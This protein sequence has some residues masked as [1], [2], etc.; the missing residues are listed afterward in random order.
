MIYTAPAKDPEP[1]P[2]CPRRRFFRRCN[3]VVRKYEFFDRATGDVV[4]PVDGLDYYKRCTCLKG[5]EF[6]L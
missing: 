1:I 5:H 3:A 2:R 4:V 6:Q